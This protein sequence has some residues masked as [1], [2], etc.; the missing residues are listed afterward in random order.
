M[1]LGHQSGKLARHIRK[2][3]QSFEVT[4]PMLDFSRS[5]G[6]FRN[7]VQD[8]Q[9]FWKPLHHIA[10]NREMPRKKKEAI[11]ESESL[12][13]AESLEKPLPQQELVIRFVVDHMHDAAEVRVPRKPHKLLNDAS[14][15]QIYPAH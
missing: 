12:Q 6:R 5:N 2:T 3:G 1:S 14:A 15:A 10:R 7:V 8:K 4:R 9:L 11:G 13:L